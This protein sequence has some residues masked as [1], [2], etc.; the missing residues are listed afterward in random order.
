[1]NVRKVG[2]LWKAV[3]V[4][5]T[6]IQMVL[7]IRVICP[8]GNQRIHNINVINIGDQFALANKLLVS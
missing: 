5:E 7:N 1:M 6:V 3:N 4:S 2:R 8:V